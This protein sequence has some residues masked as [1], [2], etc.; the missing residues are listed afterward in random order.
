MMNK[1]LPLLNMQHVITSNYYNNK[2]T[3]PPSV[4]QF[5][6]DVLNPIYALSKNVLT[7]DLS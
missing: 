2:L 6:V 3:S 4:L 7:H 5:H 1:H